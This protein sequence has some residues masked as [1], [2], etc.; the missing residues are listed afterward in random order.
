MS[1]RYSDIHRGFVQ[2]VMSRGCISEDSAN[3]VLA[4]LFAIGKN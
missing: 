1:S 3:N 2:I 4:D